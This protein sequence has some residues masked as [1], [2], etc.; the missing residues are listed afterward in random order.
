M[1]VAS[2]NARVTWRDG[3]MSQTSRSGE[4]ICG[5][6]EQTKN[7]GDMFVA[8]QNARVTCCTILPAVEND[9]MTKHRLYGGGIRCRVI[10]DVERK[11][12]K[13]EEE[14]MKEDSDE[15][16]QEEREDSPEDEKTATNVK[17]G[18]RV[19]SSHTAAWTPVRVRKVKLGT[20]GNLGLSPKSLKV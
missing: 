4:G 11:K 8:S 12:R 17:T 9:R 19:K 18:T 20:D 14:D 1:L 6:D 3:E 13:K 10:P 15:D 16:D 5:G 2:Q 7:G